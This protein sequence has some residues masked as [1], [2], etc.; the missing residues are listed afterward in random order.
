[1]VDQGSAE[2]PS[3][4]TRCGIEW[5]TA[6]R[7]REPIGDESSRVQLTISM[8]VASIAFLANLLANAFELDL[9]PRH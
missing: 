7:I 1:M 4:S 6:W 3:K 2:D 9:L 5:L 8:I